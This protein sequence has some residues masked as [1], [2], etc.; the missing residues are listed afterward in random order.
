MYGLPHRIMEYAASLPEATPLC[1]AAL[2]HNR[3][4]AL[5]GRGQATSCAYMHSTLRRSGAPCRK[6][7]GVVG[8]NDRA[9]RWR[10][11][12][13]PPRRINGYLT[14][15]PNRRLTS[16]QPSNCDTRRAGNW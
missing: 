16:A 1:P 14:S 8:R 5:S 15:G 4:Q 12:P 6:V 11:M 3:H 10:G 13:W 2:L 9:V 7:V